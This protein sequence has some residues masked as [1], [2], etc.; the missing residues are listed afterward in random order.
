MIACRYASPAPR[1]NNVICAAGLYGGLP[2]HGTCRVSCRW[3]D[4]ADAK[5]AAFEAMMNR[6][7]GAASAMGVPGC[8]RRRRLL[9]GGWSPKEAEPRT[10]HPSP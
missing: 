4:R 10:P 7:P 3:R 9:D 1:G 8:M 5:Q 2:S 6:K